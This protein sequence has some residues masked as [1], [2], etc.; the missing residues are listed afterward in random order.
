MNNVELSNEVFKIG[1]SID[2]DHGTTPR[3]VFR[4]VQNGS[5]SACFMYSAQEVQDHLHRSCMT[6]LEY[7]EGCEFTSRNILP[8]I[9][10]T[11]KHQRHANFPF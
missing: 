11:A 3:F 9:R 8:A 6:N 1:W 2:N 4:K 7:L 5:D 10:E